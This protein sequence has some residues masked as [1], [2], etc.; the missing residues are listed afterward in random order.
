MVFTTN[1]ASRAYCINSRVPPSGTADTPVAGGAIA[2]KEAFVR[3]ALRQHTRHLSQAAL[4]RLALTYGTQFG[5]VAGTIR[6]QPALGRPLSDRCPITV[7]EIAYATREES[8]VKLADALIR[9]TEAGSAAHPG[10]DALASAAGVMAREL[11]WD[12]ERVRDE[13]A[14]VDEFY[15]V[16]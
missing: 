16:P 8:A 2:D 13:V 12:S 14:A 9:R 1:R 5:R 11:G 6:Q 3:D 4:R 7:G 10:N 15:R